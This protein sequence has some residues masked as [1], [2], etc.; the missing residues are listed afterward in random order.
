MDSVTRWRPQILADVSVVIRPGERVALVG[1]SG[2]GKTTLLTL[3]AGLVAPDHRAGHSRWGA[4]VTA[5]ASRRR[6]PWCCRDTD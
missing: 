2:S 1:P 3:L 5:P 6:S 4:P